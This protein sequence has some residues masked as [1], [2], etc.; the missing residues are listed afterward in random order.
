MGDPES[1]VSEA[2]ARLPVESSVIECDPELADT[3]LFCKHYGYAAEDSANTIL[4][5]AKTGEKRTVA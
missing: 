5:T 3:A 4:V 2:L 1:N